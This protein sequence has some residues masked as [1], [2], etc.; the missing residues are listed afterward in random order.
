MLRPRIIPHTWLVN[1]CTNAPSA[2]K[3]S[4]PSMTFRR[5]SLSANT[6]VSGLAINANRLVHD[7]TRLLSNVVKGR[8]D[9]SEPTV[10]KVDEMT[11][12]LEG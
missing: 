2:N 12:V 4:A 1:A 10:T 7:V 11:P 6:P 9:R 5:P 3:A 8:F